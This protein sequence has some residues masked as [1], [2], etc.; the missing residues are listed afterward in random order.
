M[1]LFLFITNIL[2]KDNVEFDIE[3]AMSIIMYAVSR[4]NLSVVG[5]RLSCLSL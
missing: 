5:Y 4:C 1:T 2:L 3:C